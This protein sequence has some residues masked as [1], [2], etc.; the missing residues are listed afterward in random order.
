[1]GS[2]TCETKPTTNPCADDMTSVA[3]RPLEDANDPLREIKKAR[4]ERKDSKNELENHTVESYLTLKRD[5]LVAEMDTLTGKLVQDAHEAR[6]S[7][8]DIGRRRP[9]LVFTC[10]HAQ[11]RRRACGRSSRRIRWRRARGRW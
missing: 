3:T 2:D 11:R 9:G 5:Q 8:R 7:R 1:M 4:Q 6:H 10:R